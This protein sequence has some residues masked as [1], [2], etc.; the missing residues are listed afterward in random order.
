MDKL[1]ALRERQSR[2]KSNIGKSLAPSRSRGLLLPPSGS[3]P[4]APP[5][6]PL[7]HHRRRG[8][9]DKGTSDGAG[10]RHR[11]APVCAS[12]QSHQ[13]RRTSVPSPKLSLHASH[14]STRSHSGL[15]RSSSPRNP[16]SYDIAARAVN[17][18]SGF[19]MT[20]TLVERVVG[21]LHDI[22]RLNDGR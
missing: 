22:L 7:A 1:W 6:N 3:K 21:A 9:A 15:C 12:Q 16:I 18:P 13:H 5:N 8:L 4:T 14:R 11:Q 10:V 19:N 2:R 17:L 20:E